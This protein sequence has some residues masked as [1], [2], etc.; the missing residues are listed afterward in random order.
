MVAQTAE[1]MVSTMVEMMEFEREK[2]TAAQRVVQR[3][4]YLVEMKGCR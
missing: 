2:Q 4:I 3:E 1:K